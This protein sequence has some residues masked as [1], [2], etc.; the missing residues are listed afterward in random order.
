MI[1]SDSD[2]SIVVD[3]IKR[4]RKGEDVIDEATELRK[5]LLDQYG[6][7]VLD[8]GLSELFKEMNIRENFYYSRLL[9]VI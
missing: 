2:R 1:L 3:V 8:K 5:V 9:R 4:A 7:E 6:V